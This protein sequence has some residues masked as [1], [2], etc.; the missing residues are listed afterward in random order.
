MKKLLLLSVIISA[1]AL[2]AS[3]D[4]RLPDNLKPSPGQTPKPGR[5]Q[6]H[7]SMTIRIQNNL[8]EPTLKIPRSAIK[9]LRAQLDEIDG[10]NSNQSAGLNVSAT[11]TLMS[12]LFFSAAIIFGGVWMFRG[13]SFD[14]NQ[15]IVSGF[16]IFAFIGA[17]VATIFANVAP[18]P[19]EG[20]NG[21]LFSDK[22][23]NSWRGAVGKVK[24]EVE[25]KDYKN[26]P[27]ELSI[28]RSGD[29]E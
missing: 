9:D 11:Q 10:G 24:V 25:D 7:L 13:K 18:R 4:V 6:M 3:A 1:F 15:K 27:I 8:K 23:K 19:L 17:S 21:S 2:S 14:T 22:M 20:I 28:P 12:G 5:G 16:L 29:E 26:A